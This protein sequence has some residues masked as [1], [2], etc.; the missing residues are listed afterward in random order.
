MIATIQEL[1]RTRNAFSHSA[2]VSEDQAREYIADCVEDVLDVLDA[3]EQLRKI[4]LVRYQSMDGGTIKFERFDSHAK[5]KRFFEIQ[6]MG[7]VIA[8]AGPLLTRNQTLVFDSVK[9][10]SARPFLHLI[11]KTGG[12]VTEV[13]FF[14]KR[15]GSAP[16]RKL[17]FEIV[18]EALPLE[19]DCT[20]FQSEIDQIRALFGLP[21][22]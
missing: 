9:I 14:K 21:P 2:A 13:A 4:R 15:Q 16:D 17:L 3:F 11:P 10:F 6:N 5:T 7:A 20:G 8:S 22:E 19:M 18:G 1:N 12:H